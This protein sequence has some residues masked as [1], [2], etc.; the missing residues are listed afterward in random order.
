MCKQRKSK[1]APTPSKKIK[2]IHSIHY[3]STASK[4]KEAPLLGK[5]RQ[6]TTTTTTR[7][8]RINELSRRFNGIRPNY[9]WSKYLRIILA[10][11]KH[12]H[13]HHSSRFMAKLYLVINNEIFKTRKTKQKNPKNQTH[14][15]ITNYEQLPSQNKK[16]NVNNRNK[17]WY[18]QQQR[19]KLR[20]A[21]RALNNYHQNRGILGTLCYYNQL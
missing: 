18:D 6:K 19:F 15:A 3:K 4:S 17:N 11:I 1:S 10:N 2:I 5:K 12:Q 8:K 7:I 9:T 20:R 21:L 16:K 14:R 13:Q